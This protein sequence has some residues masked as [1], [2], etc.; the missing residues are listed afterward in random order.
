MHDLILAV[1]F[2]L[3]LLVPCLLTLR[4]SAA[5]EDRS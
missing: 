2:V 3:L 4:G 1:A 5:S